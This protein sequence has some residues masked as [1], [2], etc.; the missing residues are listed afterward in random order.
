MGKSTVYG[1]WLSRRLIGE[2]RS[3]VYGARIDRTTYYEVRRA[4]GQRRDIE[5]GVGEASG[6]YSFYNWRK[7]SDHIKAVI[8]KISGQAGRKESGTVLAIPNSLRLLIFHHSCI[9][10]MG[11]MKACAVL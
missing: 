2:L 9:G 6:R 8:T 4:A 5:A 1:Y 7:R 11:V 10:D 3:I